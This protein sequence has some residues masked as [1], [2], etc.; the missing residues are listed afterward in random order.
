MFFFDPNP[1]KTKM[2]GPLLIVYF[3]NEI[4]SPIYPNVYSSY[5]YIGKRLF[6]EGIYAL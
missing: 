5:E 4:L 1:T 3:M 2:H 6:Y